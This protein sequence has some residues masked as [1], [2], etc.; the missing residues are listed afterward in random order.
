VPLVGVAAAIDIQLAVK[1]TKTWNGYLVIAGN[2]TGDGF[3]NCEVFIR[4]AAGDTSLL[5]SFRTRGS[6]AG[7]YVY[8]P[9]QNF[10][11]MGSFKRTLEMNVIG[12]L[13][14]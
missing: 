1:V 14:R 3:P 10:R 11:L 5:H 4:D 12:L 13:G 2:V 7:P 9:G 8:L 6:H